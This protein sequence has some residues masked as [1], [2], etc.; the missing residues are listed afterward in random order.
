MCRQVNI[1]TEIHM[2]MY[3]YTYTIDTDRYTQMYLCTWCGCG[4][5]NVDLF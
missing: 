5:I 3:I 4:F 1:N 2:Y